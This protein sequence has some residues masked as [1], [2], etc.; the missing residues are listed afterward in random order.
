MF[1]VGPIEP[2]EIVAAHGEV[3]HIEN[4]PHHFKWALFGEFF[5]FHF[6][7]TLWIQNGFL[8]GKRFVGMRYQI[9]IHINKFNIVYIPTLS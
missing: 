8:F 2:V 7:E 5:S 6:L 4:G 3:P 1:V 9:F